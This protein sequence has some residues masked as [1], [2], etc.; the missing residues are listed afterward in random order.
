[1]RNLKIDDVT[2]AGM[3][4]DSPELLHNYTKYYHL[5]DVFLPEAKDI[6]MFGG[7]A[8]SF[9]KSFLASYKEKQLDVVEIDPGITEIAKN[10]FGLTEHSNLEIYHQ[11]ARVFL[12]TSQKKYDVILGD[13]F[14]SYY[15]IPYQLTTREAAQ[16]KYDMLTKNGIV[17]LNI[18]SSLSGEK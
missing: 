17:I 14:G 2:H 15:S 5:F 18:I 9:P 7:A 12:N 10:Y 13:A 4:L 8:Y 16:K 6:V 11:D 1:M 3:Y